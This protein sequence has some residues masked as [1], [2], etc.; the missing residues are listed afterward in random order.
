MPISGVLPLGKTR[1][2]FDNAGCNRPARGCF[3]SLTGQQFPCCFLQS[4]QLEL[5]EKHKFSFPA[6]ENGECC[7]CPASP[8]SIWS[9]VVACPKQAAM[10]I[11]GVRRPAQSCH[12][13]DFIPLS[14]P[15]TLILGAVEV[16]L[17]ELSR[18]LSPCV[19]LLLLGSV[20]R[21]SPCFQ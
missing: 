9:C 17:A 4:W 20:L 14:A 8:V 16:P 6:K 15:F 7:L 13:S 1:G 19:A 2:W 3:T 18:L 21:V 5:K 11:L 10:H 12:C